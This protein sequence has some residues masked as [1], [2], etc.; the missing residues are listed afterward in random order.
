VKAF[1]TGATGF[2]GS[3]LVEALLADGHE[4]ACLVRDPAKRARL[5]PDAPIHDIP[6]DL[7]DADALRRGCAD[8]DVVYHAAAL[9]AARSRAEFFD[10]NVAGTQRML[11]AASDTGAPRFIHVSSVA[12]SGP[13]ARGKQLREDDPPHPVTLYGESKLAAERA[14]QGSTLPWIIVRPPTV[15]GP[16]DTELARAFKLARF[17]VIPVFGDGGQELTAVYV[18][19]L[20]SALRAAA[21]RGREHNIY[22]ATHPEIFTSSEFARGIYRAVRT[23]RG[24]KAD[25][26][27]DPF[28]LP[29]PSPITRAALA[30]TGTTAKL[31]GRRT[32]LSSDKAAEF[33]AA[34]WAC[35]A[36]KM[37]D[38]TGW[39][40]ATP[41]A[42][43]L[44]QTA[45]W[46]REQGW[47]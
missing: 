19:D 17:G 6:G 46:Y 42:T 8:A 34:G 27:R 40:A 9:T 15:Y 3:H 2:V 28:V 38:D 18:G 24:A 5:F 22:F 47:I 41:I 39:N 16:R 4:V 10:I 7:H 43:G 37:A 11:H 12:V 32:L 29:L 20:I 44:P 14:V 13:V 30:I 26:V 23:A 45:R 1:V 31:L 35:S 21:D 36:S 25:D 33:L